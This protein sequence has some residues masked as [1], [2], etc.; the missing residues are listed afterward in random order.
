[1]LSLWEGKGGKAVYQ[2]QPPLGS[3][4]RAFEEIMQNWKMMKEHTAFVCTH[5]NREENELADWLAK[6]GL[7]G[8]HGT[9]AGLR[10]LFFPCFFCSQLK[11]TGKHMKSAM[12]FGK[13]S[14]ITLIFCVITSPEAKTTWSTI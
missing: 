7:K 5:I 13:F 11:L 14:N 4:R 2:F 9:V 3:D 10:T 6:M 12:R 1:M 8:L